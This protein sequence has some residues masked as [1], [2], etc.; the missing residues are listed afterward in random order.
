MSR[1]MQKAVKAIKAGDMETGRKL[2]SVIL[3]KDRNNEEAWL[4]MSRTMPEPHKKRQ[5]IERVLSINPNHEVALRIIDKMDGRTTPQPAVAPTQPQAAQQQAAPRRKMPPPPSYIPQVTPQQ[6]A[7]TRIIG[8]VAFL[9][10]GL[11]LIG[12]LIAVGYGVMDVRSFTLEEVTANVINWEIVESGSRANI[13]IDYSYEID[14]ELFERSQRVKAADLAEAQALVD[15]FGLDG[16][17]SP[18]VY[19]EAGSPQAAEFI[20]VPPGL[21]DNL[22]VGGV[23]IGIAVLSA[24]LGIGLRGSIAKPKEE[25][26]VT[27]P[28]TAA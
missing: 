15:S 12:G 28:A 3:K 6:Q 21:Y 19:Y 8:I 20:D 17:L 10:A 27:A 1:E 5:C 16:Y 11:F 14:G 24:W 7:K 13:N 4:W 26:M 18:S 2:L 9:F 25:E 23:L 22:Y